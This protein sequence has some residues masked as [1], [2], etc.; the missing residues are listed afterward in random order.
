MNKR[1]AL[2]DKHPELELL[3]CDGIG[4]DDC[5]LG[6]VERFGMEPVVAYHQPKLIDALIAQ[7]ASY[8]EACEHFD[9]NIIGSWVGDQTPAFVTPLE[10]HQN[11]P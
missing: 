6:V 4:F 3:F 9:F 8:E 2:A 5:I 11:E 1:Q 7:G 10:D